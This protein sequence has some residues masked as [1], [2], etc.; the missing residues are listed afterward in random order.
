[1]DTP[2][3][4]V[5][6]SPVS[7]FGVDENSLVG[8]SF[9]PPS[10]RP[11]LLAHGGGQT[12]HAWGKTA[13][14]LGAAGWRAYTFDQRGH[15]E[16]EWVKSG[17]YS[18]D[19]YA[20][21]LKTV[22]REIAADGGRRPVVIGASLGGVSGMLAQGES[23]NPPFEALVLVD[24][25]PR[26]ERDG[27]A[28]IIGFMAS[29]AEEGFATLDEAADEIARYL[30]DRPRPKD[31]SGLSKNLRRHD[32][33]RY[34]W[35]WDPKFLNDRAGSEDS[36]EQLSNRLGEAVRRI[37]CPLM[38]VRGQKSE[39]VTDPMVEEF[40]ALAPH[41]SFADVRA[42]GHMVA[43]DSNDPFTGKVIG[44]LNALPA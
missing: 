29:R 19:S 13:Y 14:A 44:F 38:L 33:G 36:R 35:H 15:G 40:L 22:A 2:L 28:K 27:V 32:D 26:V 30:P 7:F 41:A 9:G 42:A 6:P 23:E 18:F 39:L 17:A 10:G 25:T 21:D 24:I 12:R 1:M 8:E 3:S 16:S 4:S 31:L 5:D 20:D 37:K 34:R 43:G 11:V